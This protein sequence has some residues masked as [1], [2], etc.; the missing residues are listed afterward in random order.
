[1]ALRFHF[2]SGPF[3]VWWL[4]FVLSPAQMG[5]PPS[6][7]VHHPA[8]DTI[9]DQAQ[10]PG[11]TI[12]VFPDYADGGGWSVQLVISNVDPEAA[13]EVRVDVYDPDRQPVLDLFDSD[14]TLEIPALGSRVLR[15]GGTAAIRRGWIQAE[16]DSASVSG[17]LTYRHAQSGIEVGVK[18]VELGP[19]FALFVEE[20]PTVGAGVAVF[21][22]DASSRL[23]LRIRDEEGNDPLEGGFVSRG[24]FHQEALTLPEWFTFEGVD[25]GFLTDFRGLL[26]L[27]TEDASPFAPLG[28]RFGKGTS[29]LSAVPA[30]R[31]QSEEP[32]G[33][34]LVFPDYVDGGGWSVQ[35]VL[36]NVDPE[37]AAEVRVDVY[38]PDGQPVPDLFDSDLTLEIPAL[39]SRVWR[40]AGS[41]AIRRGWIEV[42]TDSAA[43]SGLLTYRHVQTGIEVSVEPAQLG[44]EFALFVEE[45]GTVGAGLALFK[46][47]AD[48]RIELR[49]RDEEGNDPLGGLFLPWRDFHQAA[50]TLP[51]WFDV[52]GLDAGFLT[53]YRGLLFLR[54]EDESGFAPLGLR[55]GKK[56]SSL[57]AVPAI[58]IPDGGGIDGGHPPP[59]TVTLSASP[60]SIDR[61]QSTTLTWSSTNAASA[62]ITPGIGMVPTSGS[63][64]VSPNVTTTYRITV[65]GADGQTAK[66]A[67]TVTVQAGP[68]GVVISDAILRARIEAALGK[69]RGEPITEVDME[70]LSELYA[71][72]VGIRDLTGLE[73]A[74]NLTKLS[75]G[76][77]NIS[78]ISPLSG[79]TKLETLDLQSNN[80]S[81]LSVLASLTSLEFLSIGFNGITDIS[82]LSGLTKLTELWMYGNRITDLSPVSDLTKLNTL[83]FW[84]NNVTDVSPLAGLVDLI[85]LEVGGNPITDLSPLAGLT[86]LKRLGLFNIQITDLSTLETWLPR[87]T[88]LERL[89]LY[90]TGIS[91]ISLLAGLTNLED[92]HLGA[93]GIADISPLLGL[94]NLTKL[95]L[96]ENDISNLS[97]LS[98]LTKLTE[99]RLGTNDITDV[100]ALGRL[101]RLSDLDLTFNGVTNISPLLGLTRLK[102]LDLRGNLLGDSSINDH[103]PALQDRGVLVLFDSFRKGDYDIELVFSAR[104]TDRQRR[105]LEYVAR[106][107]MAVVVEDLPDYAFTE[108]WSG[109]C[110]GQSYE[111]DAGERIDD[112]RI[113]MGTFEGG[114]AAGY[115]GPSVLRQETHLPVLGCMAF[116][117]SGA[118]LL[119]TGLHEIGH[120]LG[121]GTIWNELG[122]LQDPNGDAHFNGPLA[123][124]AFDEA[125]GSHYAGAKVPVQQGDLGHWR[126]SSFPDELMRPG[127]GS[128]LSAITVQSLADLGYGVDATQ[129]DP[130]NLSTAA[131]TSAML[132]VTISSIPGDDRSGGRL[133]SPTQANPKVWCG[134]D[135]E[136]KPIYVVD[137]QG[138]VIRTTDN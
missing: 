132:E 85:W 72:N 137:Q 103:I 107:W 102:K 88:T 79:L 26:F 116:N 76:W 80:I 131:Q 81:N 55:F 51:E 130:Y 4:F 100:S 34:D 45:S 64:T 36:S 101:F 92:L 108:G 54:T 11:G 129:A 105:V 115:G 125:G 70:T 57:S 56:T 117:L 20:T 40:S 87:R 121:F 91:D 27:E 114:N 63:R 3:F 112:L 24:D 7:N 93:N 29:S 25:T 127:G 128:L 67:V 37:A 124:A 10:E 49:L 15:S 53:D 16:T 32:Q 18:P 77:N 48:S 83:V 22:P 86:N 8:D 60:T 90:N 99:L 69:A 28:L 84:D 74:A 31:T 119:I 89:N 111:I 41:G 120:V 78:D 44:K 33:T 122:L 94:T 42:D 66:A 21:K 136:R 98:G 75:L 43:V 39:G 47:D 30:I 46:P 104:F 59:P 134:L 95:W 133:A 2:F 110:G 9:A 12:L 6:A 65:T 62:E 50:S 52:P 17:L 13:A 19:Q 123:I 118:N 126:G 135:G 106:R 1:M 97:P 58:R 82:P 109:T 61:G 14:L 35:L 5:G 38:D 23:E 71:D 73:S 138:R 113:Y 68:M 96:F